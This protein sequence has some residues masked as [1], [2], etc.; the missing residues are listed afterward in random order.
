MVVGELFACALLIYQQPG[1]VKKLKKNGDVN[2]PEWRL[3]P[4]ALG[5]ALYAIGLIRFGWAG[6]REEVTTNITTGMR[7]RKLV[8]P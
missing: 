1:Y 2:V 3:P 4:M 6:Y 5:G 7:L 8:R